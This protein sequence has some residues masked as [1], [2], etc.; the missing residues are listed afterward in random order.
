[1]AALTD[2]IDFGDSNYK[3]TRD[4]EVTTTGAIGNENCI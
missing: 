1:M 4:F 2:A 3:L